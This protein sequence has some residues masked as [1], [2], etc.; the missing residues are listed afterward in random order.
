MRNM[1]RQLRKVALIAGIAGI[2]VVM[3]A[4]AGAHV[5]IEPSS[6]PAGTDAV[7]SF[8]VPN[9]V[10]SATTTKIV[11]T[12]PA[13]HPIAEASVE[14][15]AGWTAK[16]DTTSSSTPIKTDAGTVNERVSQIT[17]SGGEIPEG[18]FQRFSISVGL[19]DSGP[20]VFKTL[21]TYSD[22]T[23]VS[24]IQDSVEGQEEPEHPAPVLTLTAAGSSGDAAPAHVAAKSDVDSAKTL[25]IIGVVLG[26]LAL[27]IAVLFG[28]MS[29]RSSATPQ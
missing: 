17:W 6:A 12:F 4:P 13:E 21:Q 3:A 15:V 5:E 8:S 27:I 25:A 7:L 11:V 23:T 19:P 9:E 16:V 29:R 24:W 10:E 14:P 2:F 18:G 22:G 26:A 1:T 20:L 28:L